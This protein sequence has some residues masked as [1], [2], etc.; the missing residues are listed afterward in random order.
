MKLYDLLH[1]QPVRL[2]VKSIP[3]RHLNDLEQNKNVLKSLLT[4]NKKLY[5]LKHKTS[6]YNLYH[7]G[8]YKEGCMIATDPICTQIYQYISYTDISTPLGAFVVMDIVW[9]NKNIKIDGVLSYFINRW[10]FIGYSGIISHNGHSEDGKKMWYNIMKKYFNE[11]DIM[12]YGGNT[13]EIIFKFD[14]NNNFDEQYNKTEK[15]MY[16]GNT[17]EK[18][19]MILGHKT[20]PNFNYR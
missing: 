7:V 1:E 11:K 15:M 13:N 10:A 12:C 17:F 14:K 8:D 2:N 18:R 19:Y 5:N 9:K 3:M 6:Q 20:M 4:P 16:D